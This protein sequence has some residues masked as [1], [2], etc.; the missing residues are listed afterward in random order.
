MKEKLRKVIF[1]LNEQNLTIGDLGFEDP[2][3]IKD[4]RHGYFHQFG[5]IIVYDP[6]QEL[7]FPKTVAIIEEIETGKVYEVSHHCFRF[8]N[9]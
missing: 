1:C 7:F 8:E 3:G 6:K 9:D 5:N 4:E 2:E